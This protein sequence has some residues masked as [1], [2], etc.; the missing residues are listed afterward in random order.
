MAK[1]EQWSITFDAYLRFVISQ[2][3]G[4]FGTSRSDV[5]QHMVRSW[6][7]DHPE[8]VSQARASI[9]HWRARKRKG[10]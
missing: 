9:E 10:R 3:E 1:N 8:Q 6:V 7:S 4:V 5:V 2:F